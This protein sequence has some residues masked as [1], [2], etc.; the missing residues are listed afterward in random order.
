MFFSTNT[1]LNVRQN[2]PKMNEYGNIERTGIING[3]KY[4]QLTAIMAGP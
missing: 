1:F 2:Y 4:M 3:I